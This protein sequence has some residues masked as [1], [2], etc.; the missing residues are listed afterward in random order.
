MVKAMTNLPHLA[1]RILMFRL[2]PRAG[3]GILRTDEF[4]ASGT[5]HTSSL[6][7]KNNSNADA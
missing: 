7:R 5:D 3:R 2:Y 6:S 1:R 4:I